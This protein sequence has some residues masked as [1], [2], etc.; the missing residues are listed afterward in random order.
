MS[1]RKRKIVKKLSKEHKQL[2][3]ALLIGDGTISSNFVF[4]LSHSE[5]Q[6][7]FL[8]WKINLL[9]TL[10]IKNNGIKEYISKNGYN[11]GK[12]V[13][14]SQMSL[15][16]TIKALRRTIYVPKKTFTRNL[17]NW[18]DEKG[19]AIWFMDDGHINVNTSEQRSSTQHTIK[20]STCVDLDTANMMIEYFKEIWNIKFRL[21]K[22]K[23]NYSLATSSEQDCENFVKI[24]KPYILQVPSLL[25]KIR[26]DFTKE[27]FI[28]KQLDGFEVRDI[29][30]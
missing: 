8:E 10:N 23:T 17:L 2:L 28:E 13:L 29:I 7:E 24:I 26:K 15:N 19:L 3:V 25:Y 27:Q 20:I 22:E 21:L 5:N 4:K 30:F 11:K 6:R 18:L 12:K 9:N 16:P 14:Y 1:K